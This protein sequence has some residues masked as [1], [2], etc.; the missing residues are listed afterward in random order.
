MI[1]GKSFS[2]E[3]KQVLYLSIGFCIPLIFASLAYT[4]TCPYNTFEQDGIDVINSLGYSSAEKVYVG[5]YSTTT[6]ARDAVRTAIGC[7]TCSI[8]SNYSISS[9]VY[10]YLYNHVSGYS[11]YKTTYAVYVADIDVCTAIPD[12]DGDGIA[13]DFDLKPNSSD[14][15]KAAIVSVCYDQ[16]NKVV[17]GIIQDGEGNQ[18]SFG[19]L[20]TDYEG[21]T[22][23]SVTGDLRTFQTAEDLAAS[24]EKLDIDN[25]N[26]TK[27]NNPVEIQ[28]DGTIIPGST[29]PFKDYRDAEDD[30]TEAKQP[31]TQQAP[32]EQPDLNDGDSD[33]LDKVIKNTASTNTNLENIQKYLG[34]TNDYLAKI[35]DKTGTASSTSSGGSVVSVTTPTA[36][37]IGQAVGDNLIDSSQTIDTTVT[38]NIPDLDETD[39]LTTIKTKYSDRYDLFITTLKGSDL[40]SLP[41][42]IFSGPSGSGSSIQTVNIGKWGASSEQTATIDYS[43]YDN[44]WQVLRSVLLLVTSFA[45]FKIL[46][47]KKG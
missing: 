27:Q 5:T 16:N 8:N 47:L 39:T 2:G 45:C 38:D 23:D 6:E 3:M 12:T 28:D 42:G 4:Q 34:I 11:V 20:P 25:L 31:D 37:E 41:F 24:L 26:I 9:G 17:A 22:I 1:G 14:S 21:Y 35:N 13:D 46:V 43:D 32:S 10:L 18:Y 7:S 44:I 19:T 15:Y 29:D 30:Q 33:R 40:F 36:D